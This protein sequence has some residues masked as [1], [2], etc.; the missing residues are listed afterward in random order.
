MQRRLLTIIIAVLMATFLLV[1]IAVLAQTNEPEP[2]LKKSVEDE[3]IVKFKPQVPESSKVNIIKSKDAEVKKPLVDSDSQ[4]IQ[5]NETAGVDKTVNEL[6]NQPEVQYVERNQL[7]KAEMIPNDPLYHY[8]WDMTQINMPSAWDITT[9]QG[10]VVAVVDTGVSY[11]N[12]SNFHRLSD[13]AA[14]HFTGG[15]NFIANNAHPD[16]DNGH[17]SHVAGTIAQSTNNGRGVAGIAYGATIMPVKVLS[18][19]GWG[20]T[21]GVA[22]GIRWAADHGAKVINLSLGSDYPS[23]AMEDAVN[24]ARNQKNVVVVA[25]AG[26]SSRNSLIYPAAYNSVISVAATDYNKNLTWYSQYGSGLDISAP[27]GDT[28]VDKNGDHLADGILQQT[29]GSHDPTTEGY[30]LYQGTSMATPHVSGVA[31][32]LISQGVNSA[33]D[34]YQILTSTAKD[35]GTPGYDTR[36]GY[37]LLDAAAAV[38]SRALTAPKI[39]YPVGGESLKGGDSINIS[40]DN[41][42]GQNLNYNL[43]YTTDGGSGRWTEITAATSPG[44][45]SYRWQLPNIDSRNFQIRVRAVKGSSS[46]AWSSSG[47]L[48]IAKAPIAE[49]WWDSGPG[50]WGWAGS[51]TVIGDFN[52][53]GHSDV[54]IL[55]GYKGSRSKL[56]VFTSNGTSFNNPALWWDSGPGHWDWAGSKLTAGDFNGDNKDD[57]GILY[58]YATQRD[59]KAFVLPSNGNKFSG[60]NEW[61]HAGRGNWDWSGSKLTAGDF[62]GDNKDDIGILYG[63]AAQRDV[64]AFVLPSNGNKF[65]GANEWWHAGRGNWDW[66]GSK[67]AAGNFN[68]DN[69]DDLA[70]FYGYA[71]QR[72]AKVFILPS[73]GTKLA[74]VDE[75]WHAGTG[76]WDWSSSKLMTGDIDGSSQDEFIVLYNYGNN[77]SRLWKLLQ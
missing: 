23:K 69:K 13:L 24:Y 33:S 36:Y 67:L 43:A 4:L 75:W 29:I 46:S 72:D 30:Y 77:L 15:W 48:A 74:G 19:S 10:A 53:D 54:A 9:G 2:G 26:N 52:G 1:P 56:W 68:G 32:L 37:G 50:N 6:K 5:V 22:D 14:T 47:K 58:G 8:Q 7:V 66:A 18:G 64:K 35:L 34:V 28:G 49:L 40:W 17:G 12:Y 65:S 21:S 3:V 38:E 16:D 39:T 25:A 31:T 11:E 45:T 51:K 20:T 61:W 62:N 41:Q 70:I 73:S 76:N 59:V 42:G 71:A 60:A 63:Y 57:I 27:G 44:A 55:Y